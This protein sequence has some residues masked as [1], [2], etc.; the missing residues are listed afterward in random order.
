MEQLEFDTDIR[1]IELSRQLIIDKEVEEFRKR[2]ESVMSKEEL[3]TIWNIFSKI[4]LRELC[5]HWVKPI[6]FLNYIIK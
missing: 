2:I 1:T 6:V 5:E 3:E 4:P